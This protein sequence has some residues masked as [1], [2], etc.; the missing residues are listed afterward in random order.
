MRIEKEDE[1]GETICTTYSKRGFYY[2][3]EYAVE[4]LDVTEDGIRA[5]VIGTEDYEVEI[6]LENGDVTNMY[7]SCPYAESG[8]NCKHMAAVLFEWSEECDDDMEKNEE[9]D[10]YIFAQPSNTEEYRKKPRGWQKNIF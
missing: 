2:H 10:E 3:C 7:C 9:A 6:S 4:N 8:N 1:L 5:D